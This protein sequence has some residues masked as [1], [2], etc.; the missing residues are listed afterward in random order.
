MKAFVLI[1]SGKGSM[2]KVTEE[3]RKLDGVEMAYAVTGQY[4]VIAFVEFEK[5]NSLSQMIEKI[6]SIEGAQ[7]TTTAIVMPQKNP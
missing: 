7:R 2:W 5:I 1:T 3:V 4:D 6:Q